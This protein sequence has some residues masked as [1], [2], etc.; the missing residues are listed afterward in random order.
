MFY[1][2]EISFLTYALLSP[3]RLAIS[4]WSSYVSHSKDVAMVFERINTHSCT[5]HLAG[6][7]IYCPGCHLSCSRWRVFA[8]PVIV[9]SREIFTEEQ[10]EQ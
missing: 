4:F 10:A 1:T 6:R 8:R 2:G 3:H 5:A 9:A 7:M